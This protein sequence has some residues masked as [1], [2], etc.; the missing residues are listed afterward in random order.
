[1]GKKVIVYGEKG[2]SLWGKGDS[3]WGKGDSLWGNPLNSYLP[4]A[5]RCLFFRER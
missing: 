3:L 2:D 1:M 4:Q 5:F